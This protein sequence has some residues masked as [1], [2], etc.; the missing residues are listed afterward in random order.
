MEST[1]SD[2]FDEKM[3]CGFVQK[4]PLRLVGGYKGTLIVPLI[5]PL[6]LP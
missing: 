3:E 6:L 4:M 1:V 2:G 5:E